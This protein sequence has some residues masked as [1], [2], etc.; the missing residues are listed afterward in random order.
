ML[1]GTQFDDVGDKKMARN[2][3][4]KHGAQDEIDA[5][6]VVAAN[7]D[8]NAILQTVNRCSAG[9]TRES[10]IVPS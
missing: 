9:N 1:S 8:E 5:A 7:T 3:G 2:E 10:T 6:V 4:I